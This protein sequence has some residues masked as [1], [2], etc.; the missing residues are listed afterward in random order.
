MSADASPTYAAGELRDRLANE[1]TL[2]AW[3]RTA[4]AVIGFGVVVAKFSFF[5]TPTGSPTPDTALAARLTGTLLAL[6]G[7]LFIALG[8]QRTRVYARL[9]DP[10]GRAPNDRALVVTSAIIAL[11]GL[12]VAL[13][14][15]LS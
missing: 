11:T 2:L 12:I 7:V 14:L 5:M 6:L 1:R 15:A 13:Y 9:I 8:A 3:L 10:R 4:L